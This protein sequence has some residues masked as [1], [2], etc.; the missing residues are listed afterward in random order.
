MPAGGGHNQR[1]KQSLQAEQ[2]CIASSFRPWVCLPTRSNL[3]GAWVFTKLDPPGDSKLCRERAGGE[4][5]SKK[6][7]GAIRYVGCHSVCATSHSHENQSRGPSCQPSSPKVTSM[8]QSQSV[9]GE[10]FRKKIRE[11]PSLIPQIYYCKLPADLINGSS[12]LGGNLS[13]TRYLLMCLDIFS[14]NNQQEVEYRK[15]LTS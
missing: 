8:K 15:L 5:G 1:E 2:H 14:C 7:R 10:T 3:P 13:P 4:G 11:N 12:R 9:G 6:T